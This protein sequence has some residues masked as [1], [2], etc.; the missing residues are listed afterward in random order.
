AIEAFGDVHVLCNNAGVGGGSP[1]VEADLDQWAWVLGVNLF[2]VVH[3]V[4]AFLPGM[5]KHGEEGHIVNTASMAGVMITTPGNAPYAASKAAIVALSEILH[6]ELVAAGGRIGVSVVLPGSTDTRIAAAA[7]NRPGAPES[8][9]EVPTL[10]QLIPDEDAGPGGILSPS[11]LAEIV[12]DAIRD[13]TFY[14]LTH[15]MWTDGIR[16]RTTAMLEG[17]DPKTASVHPDTS[18]MSRPSSD[19]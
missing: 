13:R 18:R 2:G 19:S 5:L 1:M 15:P 6:L 17:T 14:V 7:R 16:E 4:R 8:A 11:A 3:G 10:S 9:D 12:H